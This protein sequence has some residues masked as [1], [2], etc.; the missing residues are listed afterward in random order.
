MNEFRWL[1]IRIGPRSPDAEFYPVEAH[2]DDGSHFAGGELRLDPQK[3]SPGERTVEA[4]GLD[5]FDVLCAGPIRRAFDRASGRAEA[6]TAGRLRIRLWIDARAVELHAIPWERLFYLQRGQPTPLAAS[7]FTPFSRYVGLEL[8]SPT[9][10]AS[11]PA[12]PRSIPFARRRRCA[13]RW[14]T[15]PRRA[16]ST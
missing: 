7:T 1:E 10:L 8:R 11:P 13:R 15:C 12:S 16:N 5:L 2:L 14:A 9:P 6:E 4:Y 3:L